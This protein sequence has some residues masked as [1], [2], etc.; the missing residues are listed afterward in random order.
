MIRTVADLLHELMQ[1]EAA[2][3][4]EVAVKHGP[5]IGD[6][7]EGLTQH[8]LSRAVPS[9]FGLRVVSG[10]IEDGLGSF[11]GEIDCMLV[12]GKGKAIPYTGKYVW[13]TKDVI[14]V[15]EIKKSLYGQ[16]LADAFNHLADVKNVERRYIDSGQADASRSPDLTLVY[17]TFGQITGKTVSSLQDFARLPLADRAVF[18]A[19]VSERLGSIR[20]IFGYRGFRS[21]KNFR[22]SLHE[23][24][25]RKS[26]KAGLGIAGF[27]HLVVSG[28]YAL[29]KANGLP[30]VPFAVPPE[31]H[32]YC[33]TRASNPLIFLLEL[34]W[35]RLGE[36]YSLG[37]L[38]GEDLEEDVVHAFLS[39]RARVRDERP[40]WEI[41]YHDWP[42]DVLRSTSALVKPWEPTYL[43]NEQAAVFSALLRGNEVDVR[44]PELLAFLAE[45]RADI[46]QFIASMVATQL[47]ALNGTRIEL[48]TERCKIIPLPDGR[49]VVADDNT[50]R[51]TR[52]V[53]A[54]YGDGFDTEPRS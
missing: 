47:V 12:S 35:T 17:R 22:D 14:A 44:Q 50:G 41:T 40:T 20:V 24:I 32:F 26:G 7:Y 34:I 18:N 2:K 8:V 52:W 39:A 38:W 15:V 54:K 9:E 5:T 30:Y 28:E 36:D 1:R 23:V 33:S 6:M 10:F 49:I 4:D 42:K 16:D 31:W 21:E 51:L 53:I 45:R 25:Q 43:D 11:S 48:I 19:L 3:L 46:D 13:H 37:G 27:P 29:V